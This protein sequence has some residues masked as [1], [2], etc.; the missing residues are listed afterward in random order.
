MLSTVEGRKGGREEER[1]VGVLTIHNIKTLIDWTVKPPRY[2]IVKSLVYNSQTTD[3]LI[4]K[5]LSEIESPFN[6]LNSCTKY[7][8]LILYAIFLLYI[9]GFYKKHGVCFTILKDNDYNLC[10]I[11]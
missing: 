7:I 11:Y 4:F 1:Y 6:S 2:S 5:A 8:Y 9:Y 3:L 10:S